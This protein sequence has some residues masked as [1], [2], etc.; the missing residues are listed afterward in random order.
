MAQPVTRVAA[1]V[2]TDR[3]SPKM[4]K[5][6]FQ[7]K[8]PAITTTRARPENHFAPFVMRFNFSELLFLTFIV[9]LQCFDKLAE[10]RGVDRYVPLGSKA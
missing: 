9:S 2:F 8:A 5:L 7:L 6:A 4:V 1:R 3:F 10:T